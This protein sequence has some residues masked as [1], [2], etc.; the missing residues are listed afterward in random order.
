M[1]TCSKCKKE[2]PATPEYFYREL[3]NK[4]GLH[5]LCKLCKKDI[6]Y[7]SR[8]RN[9]NY[10]EYQLSP[11]FVY[12]QLKH[13]AKKRNITFAISKDYYLANLIN[14]PCY[15]CNSNNTKHWIDR[16]HNDHKIGYTEANS[17]PCCQL[18]NR[19]KIALDPDV[20]INQCKA[21]VDNNKKRFHN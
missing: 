21:I 6:D 13:Q 7:K 15:Y 9:S 19:M 12:A 18:C 4:D 11:S 17:V 5:Y 10:K 3:R 8:N 2:Y 20:F 14:K 16:Y 1:K